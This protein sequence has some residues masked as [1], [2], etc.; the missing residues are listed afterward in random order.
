M[1]NPDPPASH[2]ATTGTLEH[3]TLR[4]TST[5]DLGGFSQTLSGQLHRRSRPSRKAAEQVD[6]WSIDSGAVV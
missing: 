1:V 6:S 4:M 3:I 2:S 5:F